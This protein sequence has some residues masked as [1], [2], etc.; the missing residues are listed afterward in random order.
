MNNELEEGGYAFPHAI[1]TNQ[2]IVS[3]GMTLRDYFAGHALVGLL[4]KD[5]SRVML[6]ITPEWIAEAAYGQADAMLA[7]RNK[8]QNA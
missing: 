7:E 1:P 5:Y 4:N 8:N 3:R 2:N 6:C